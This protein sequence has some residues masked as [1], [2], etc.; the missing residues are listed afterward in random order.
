M[1]S[2]EN[3]IQEDYQ[4]DSL[5]SFLVEAHESQENGKLIHFKFLEISV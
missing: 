5:S 4:Y 3:L 1:S 2:L